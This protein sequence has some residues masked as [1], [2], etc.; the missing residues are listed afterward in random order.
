LNNIIRCES[1]HNYTKFFL[2]DNTKLFVSK[3][4]KEYVIL[5]ESYNFIRPHQRHLVNTKYIKSFLKEYGGELLLH[6]GT[7]IPVSRRKKDEVLSKL[8]NF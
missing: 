3:T 7:R 8:N 2:K 1:D 6:D 5:L 4:I